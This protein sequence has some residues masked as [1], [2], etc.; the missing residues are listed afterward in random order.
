MEWFVI[1]S[2]IVRA[3]KATDL[4]LMKIMVQ[5]KPRT[6]MKLQLGKNFYLVYLWER[7]EEAFKRLLG[8]QAVMS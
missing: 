6:P 3:A 4:S 7:F 5:G 2:T 1:F 8:D